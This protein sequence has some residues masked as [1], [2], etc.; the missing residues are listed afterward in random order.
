MHTGSAT[1]PPAKT[2][3]QTTRSTKLPRSRLGVQARNGHQQTYRDRRH[4]V[5]PR[6]RERSARRP[7]HRL[8]QH[9]V[10]EGRAPS[11]PRSLTAINNLSRPTISRWSTQTGKVGTAT[12]PPPG[13]V[14]AFR[15]G[16]TSAVSSSLAYGY[17]QPIATGDKPLVHPTGK[18]GTAADPS[19]IRQ[20]ATQGQARAP[21]LDALEQRYETH[22]ARALPVVWRQERWA[23]FSST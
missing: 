23:P 18:V 6:R 21:A 4:A 9:S 10:G 19:P 17:Q 14:A 16:G 3:R 5:G 20:V 2:P 8:S 13:V 12:D 7:T 11:R 22:C 15:R 1:P